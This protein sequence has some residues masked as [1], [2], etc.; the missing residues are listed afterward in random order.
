ME[1]ARCFYCKGPMR[2]DGLRILL[3]CPACGAW[4]F[5]GEAAMNATVSDDDLI[6][7]GNDDATP[8]PS[9]PKVE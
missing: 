3:R 8:P 9:P 4:N 1:Q 5:D 6:V 7:I 2:P